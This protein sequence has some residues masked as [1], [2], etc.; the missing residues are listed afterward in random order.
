MPKIIIEPLGQH[1]DRV[2][3]DCGHPRVNNFIRMTARKHIAENLAV[4]RV[5]VAVGEAT[6]IGYHSM[7]AHSISGDDLPVELRP[8][9]RPFPGIGAFYLGF[10]GVQ[11]HFQGKAIGRALL[12]DAMKQTVAASAYGAIAF[13][14]LDALD[15]ERVGFYRNLGFQSLPS[16][17]MRM[18]IPTETMRRAQGA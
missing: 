7:S 18:I 3:F 6:V 13:L 2:A 1:H 15:E 4:V 11:K 10:L 16:Q 5:A 14:V 9:G 8:K 12:A 17:P